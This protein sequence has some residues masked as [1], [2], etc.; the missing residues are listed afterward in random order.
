ME[1]LIVI[2]ILGVV[3]ALAIPGLMSAKQAG[4][5]ASAI[6]SMRAINSA[7]F[8]Y[9][10][11]CGSGYF[12]PNLPV[13]GV[14][15]AGATPYLS[16][17]LTAAVTVVK[18]QYSVTMG[19]T[20]GPVVSAPA[21]CNGVGAGVA[22]ASYWATATPTA[23]AGTHAFGTNVGGVVYQASQMAQLAMTDTTAPAGAVPLK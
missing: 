9:A 17:D 1:L 22:T 15:A 16:P 6:G 11:T 3:A 8:V 18:T 23:G 19:S 2:G 7:Q 10:T 21:T 20:V 13:L 4:A 5:E 12:A 14:P